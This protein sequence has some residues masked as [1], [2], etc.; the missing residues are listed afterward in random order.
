MKSKQWFDTL[1]AMNYLRGVYG[2]AAYC[3][4]D[5]WFVGVVA[6]LIA[7]TKPKKRRVVTNS[8]AYSYVFKLPL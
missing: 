5:E 6:A 4:D 7:P 3:I 8:A 1:W 2:I